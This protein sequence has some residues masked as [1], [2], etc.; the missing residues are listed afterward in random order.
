MDKHTDLIVRL[1]N[2]SRRYF[3]ACVAQEPLLSVHDV[4]DLA[5]D[6]MVAIIPRLE[7]LR[8]PDHYARRMARNRVIRELKRRRMDPSIGIPDYLRDG[9]A[10]ADVPD[11]DQDGDDDALSDNDHRLLAVAQDLLLGEDETTRVMVASRCSVPES[12]FHEISQQTG[13]SS[14]ALRMRMTRFRKRVQSALPSDVANEDRSAHPENPAGR[15][16]VHR[17]KTR[18]S[19]LLKV[20]LPSS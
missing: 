5:S 15:V 6:V 9:P 18:K 10:L 8:K 3:R 17:T 14:S 4:D 12:T 16:V 19:C 20:R 1:W 11:T 13:V 2:D 7:G